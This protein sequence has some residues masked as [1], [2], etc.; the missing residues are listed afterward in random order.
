MRKI[1]F[2]RLNYNRIVLFSFCILFNYC[3]IYGQLSLDLGND[4]TYCTGLYFN[5]NMVL[6]PNATIKN[7][8]EPISYTWDCQLKLSETLVF[9]ASDFLDDTTQI[10]PKFIEQIRWSEWIKFKLTV[11]DATGSSAADSLKVRFSSFVYMSTN[12]TFN[13]NHGESVYFSWD[14]LIGGGIAPLSFHWTPSKWLSDSADVNTWCKPES[15]ISYYLIATDSCG[16]ESNPHLTYIIS[17]IP[18]G[19]P[20]KIEKKSAPYEVR[21]TKLY[22]K[23][24]NRYKTKISIRSPDGRLI[25]ENYLNNSYI[26]L[27]NYISNPGL[28]IITIEIDQKYSFQ[29]YNN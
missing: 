23:A 25:N 18:D 16:C 5:D 6:A 9:T 14:P 8:I 27:D 15:D 11:T 19:I 12:F 4:T 3:N 20:E 21:G 1:I 29:F 22:L 7:A 17:L 10:S 2:R 24:P 28:Y 26:D 13:I